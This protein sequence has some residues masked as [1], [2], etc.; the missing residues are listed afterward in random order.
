MYNGEIVF[1]IADI[2]HIE[3]DFGSEMTPTKIVNKGEV[4][5]LGRKAPK[6]RWVYKI[7]YNN[8]QE[9][10]ESLDKMVNQ[11]CSKAEY[12]NELNKT[13]EDVSI[14]IYM[15]SEFAEID[16]SIPNYILKKISLLDC[17]LNFS[18]FSFGMATDE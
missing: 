17:T 10:I 8:E 15:R 9:Y 6:N 2:K 12:V 3:V 18:I 11:L 14:N 7:A 4:I 13:Y 5:A 16:Y 1:D